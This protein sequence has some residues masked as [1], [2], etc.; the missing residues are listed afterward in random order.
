MRHLPEPINMGGRRVRMNPR[1][2]G[3]I[4]IVESH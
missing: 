2:D 4:V 3:D 1:A